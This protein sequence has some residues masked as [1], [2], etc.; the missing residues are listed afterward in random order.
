M[1]FSVPPIHPH[2]HPP[3]HP[4]PAHPRTRAPSHHY[5]A[6]GL[7]S[8]L[9]T[10]M[11][12]VSTDTTFSYSNLKINATSVSHCEAVAVTV[13]VANTGEVDSDEVVQ[14][15]VSTPHATVPAPKVRLADFTR[16]HIHAGTVTTV[17]LIVSPKAHSVVLEDVS[18]SEPKFWEPTIAVE[19]GRISLYVGGSQP[20]IGAETLEGNVTISKGGMLGDCSQ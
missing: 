3:S 16:V 17:A 19:A 12:A 9:L 4:P 13:D 5:R 18:G 20:N 7:R 8:S 11:R 2:R 10:R 6:T 14:L 15:Y 1:R